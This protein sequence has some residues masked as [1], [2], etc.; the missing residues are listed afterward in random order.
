MRPLVQHRVG[1]F[2]FFPFCA[3]R[4]AVLRRTAC[5]CPAARLA[6]PALP[7]SCPC[8]PGMRIP[9]RRMPSRLSTTP[10]NSP[11][12]APCRMPHLCYLYIPL[13]RRGFCQAHGGTMF[14]NPLCASPPMN[15]RIV[16]TAGRS[17]GCDST[18]RLVAYHADVWHGCTLPWIV[19]NLQPSLRMSATLV[20]MTLLDASRS[21]KPSAFSRRSVSGWG[22]A[23]DGIYTGR[24]VGPSS[25][26]AMRL[27]MS[28]IG[29]PI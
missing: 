2:F 5:L 22:I 6:T 8:P 28:L 18:T 16:G 26:T 14:T 27:V 23:L 17:T 15:P 21:K 20:W 25:R 9:T 3:R 10:A 12:S 19:M 4:A 13:G 11:R 7:L 29:Y 24:T 1:L